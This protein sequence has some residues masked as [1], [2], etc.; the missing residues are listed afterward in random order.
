MLIVDLTEL[1]IDLLGSFFGGTAST[2]I[3]AATQLAA[4]KF[5]EQIGKAGLSV[6]C[7]REATLD[8]TKLRYSQSG[9]VNGRVCA[10]HILQ[11]VAKAVSD[12]GKTYGRRVSVFVAPHDSGVELRSTRGS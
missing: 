6:A 3:V 12:Y 2:P 1:R 4:L 10:G 5:R 11:F 9:A 7:V 8:I